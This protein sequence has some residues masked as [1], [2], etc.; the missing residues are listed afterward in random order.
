MNHNN[1]DSMDQHRPFISA[2]CG[3]LR[4]QVEDERAHFELEET[5]AEPNSDAKREFRDKRR[6][7]EVRLRRLEE[8]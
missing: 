3:L 1:D 4:E 5:L 6:D 7:A 8:T 2:V